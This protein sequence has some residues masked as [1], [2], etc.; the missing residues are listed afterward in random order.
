MGGTKTNDGLSLDKSMDR[1]RPEIG[2]LNSATGRKRG[3]K[4][5]ESC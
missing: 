2:E 1:Y 5:G 3:G 4:E